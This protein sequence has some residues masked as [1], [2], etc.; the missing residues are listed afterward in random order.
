MSREPFS[1]IYENVFAKIN[2]LPCNVPGSLFIVNLTGQVVCS[3]SFGETAELENK[4][5]IHEYTYY[6]VPI[7][8][9]GKPAGNLKLMVRKEHAG[10]YWE[11]FLSLTAAAI[12]SGI[13]SFRSEMEKIEIYVDMGEE[14]FRKELMFEITRKFHSTINAEQVLKEVFHTLE[15][16]FP[17]IRVELYLSQDFQTS[18]PINSLVDTDEELIISAYREGVCKHKSEEDMNQV[19]IPLRGNQGVYG[20]LL[21]QSSNLYQ[22][23]ERDHK[24]MEFVGDSAGTAFENAQLYEQSR[25]L[26]RELRLINEMA[27]QL[28][29]SLK[30]KDVLDYILGEIQQAFK[31]NYCFIFSY[32]AIEKEFTIMSSFQKE[33]LGLRFKDHIGYLGKLAKTKEAYIVSDYI[34]REA[35]NVYTEMFGHRSMMLV[36]LLQQGNLK[37]AL[38]V[39]DKR[40]NYFTYE[41]FK[42]LQL[43]AQHITLAILN[44]NLHLEMERLII[45]DNLTG[46]HTRRYL[47]EQVLHSFERDPGGSLILI[48][49]DFFKKVND[50]HG[51]QVGDEVLIQVARVIRECTRSGDIAARWGGEELAVYLPSVEHSA[52]LNIAERIRNKVQEST[53]PEVTVS[54]GVSSWNKEQMVTMKQLFNEADVALYHAKNNGKN[55]VV[56]AIAINS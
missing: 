5:P 23:N 42:L 25:K 38:A 52:A 34:T 41:D 13:K 16:L 29:K 54:I 15:E 18:L 36:P 49:I 28:N 19:A 24:F 1:N 43:I 10:D 44:A 50:L 51:H 48:D 40:Q 11:D 39:L 35:P 17:D 4:E 46:L 33:Y 47:D 14:V 8:D 26:I 12:E 7:R 31:P 9:Q 30:L 56:S 20:V 6:E 53:R 45:T 27:R 21:L 55:Q 32:D 22:F 2:R 37:G 3:K